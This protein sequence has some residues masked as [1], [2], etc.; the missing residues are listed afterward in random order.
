MK[1]LWYHL[2][3]VQNAR[4]NK[5]KKVR[6]RAHDLS[7]LLGDHHDL[8]VLHEDAEGRAGL[9]RRETLDGLD[10]MID[11]RQAELLDEA[12]SLGAELYP[13]KPKKFVSRIEGYWTE[14]R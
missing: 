12:L 13:G 7:D 1:D 10:E 8:A 4:P 3:I 5:L 9:L 2:R 11:Q 14:W 6:D